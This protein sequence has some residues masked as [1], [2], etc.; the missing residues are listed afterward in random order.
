MPTWLGVDILSTVGRFLVALFNDC[1]LGKS[2]QIANPTIVIVDPTLYYSTH[3]C[4][5]L[6]ANTGKLAIRN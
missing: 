3:A 2:G 1:V 5:L 4:Y 6:I